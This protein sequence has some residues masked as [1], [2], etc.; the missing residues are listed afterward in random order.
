MPDVPAVVPGLP[1]LDFAG[2]DGVELPVW[3]FVSLPSA[4]GRACQSAADASGRA[5]QRCR[6]PG[7]AGPA[8][9]RRS[10]GPRADSPRVPGPSGRCGTWRSAS[11]RRRCP[12]GSASGRTAGRVRRRWPGCRRWAAARRR[13]AP[14]PATAGRVRQDPRGPWPGRSPAARPG[15]RAGHAATGGRIRSC[16]PYRGSTRAGTHDARTLAGN[17]RRSC[18]QCRSVGETPKVPTGTL[19]SQSRPGTLPAW[20]HSRVVLPGV[21]ADAGE[22]ALE[23][24]QLALDGGR[25]GAALGVPAV[26]RAL[27][28][29]DR[30]DLRRQVLRDGG[31]FLVRQVPEFDAAAFGLLDGGTGELMRL[32]ER[33]ALA[34]QPFGDVR[35]QR[36]ALRGQRFHPFGVERQRRDHAGD[37]R[38]Q[39]L[40][41]VGGV[42]D[43]FLVLLQVAVVR[44]RQALQAWPAARSGCRSAGRPCRVPVPRRRGSSSAA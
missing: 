43:R 26:E 8:A 14:R 15:N 36:E 24:Q 23:G 17:R 12:S 19:A 18:S 1:E 7:P 3:V 31:V 44:E 39:D 42:E 34:D 21:L 11:R 30:A 35:G 16:P 9:A 13:A 2:P 29:Q 25:R 41:G 4:P 38:E 5:R 10:S 32:A 33:H 28:G 6:R 20:A 22:L 27:G 40:Q 37:C